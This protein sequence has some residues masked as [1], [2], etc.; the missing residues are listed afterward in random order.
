MVFT[1]QPLDVARNEFRLLRLHPAE[2]FDAP[3][4]VG[5]F[6]A[7]L[8]AAPEYEALSYVWGKPWGDFS[9][10]VTDAR[11]AADDD[12][13]AELSSLPIT[14]Y[15]DTALRQVRFRG[16]DRILWVDALCI[17]Q[18]DLAERSR[19]VQQMRRIYESCVADVAYLGPHPPLP[20]TDKDV[21]DVD[22]DTDEARAAQ[23]VGAVAGETDEQAAARTL[24]AKQAW[25]RS[26]AEQRRVGNSSR[27]AQKLRDGLALMRQIADRDAAALT[28]M[29]QRWKDIGSFSFMDDAE[30][31]AEKD[32]AKPVKDEY[33]P[34]DSRQ[35]RYLDFKQI[36]SLYATFSD[37]EL[38]TRV[39]I[40]QELSCAPRVLLAVGKHH[41]Y[42]GGQ[43]EGDTGG[44]VDVPTD[45]G[46]ED[47]GGGKAD[48]LDTLDTL[49][50]DRD[51]VGGFLDDFA[52]ADAFH[53]SWSHGTVGPAAHRIFSRVRSIHLQRQ[54]IR[55]TRTEH[56]GTGFLRR[57]TRGGFF[58]E[59]EELE[60]ELLKSSVD[61]G[62]VEGKKEAKEAK[63]STVA[64]EAPSDPSLINVL[65]R[66]K[67]TQATDARDKVYG[68]LGLV[69]E[70]PRLPPVDY[71]QPVAS[72]YSD[73]A[74]AIIETSGTLDVISQNPFDGD[75]DDDDNETG[76]K[77]R[78]PG[79]PSW[80]PNFD[81][82]FYTDFYDEFATILFAQRGIYAAGKPDCKHL[83]PLQVEEG[84]FGGVA[85]EGGDAD[86]QAPITFRSLRLRGTMLGRV[87][88]LK[89]G[90]W[91]ENGK[92]YVDFGDGVA[93]FSHYK[94][95]YYDT[96]EGVEG[97]EGVEGGER[98]E[99]GKP[100]S[101]KTVYAATGEP[102]WDAFW[103]TISGD[104][105]AYPIR[106]LTAE[107][108][109]QCSSGLAEVCRLHEAELEKERNETKGFT[110]DEEWEKYRRN[111]VYNNDQ[112]ST[113]LVETLPATRILRR[114]ARRWGMAHTVQDGR[115]P[116][117]GGLLLM[118]RAVAAPGDVVAVLD[119]SK[120]PVVL[121]AQDAGALSTGAGDGDDG[122]TAY[123]KYVCP[124]YVHGYMDGEAVAQV[125]DGRL[126]EQDIVLV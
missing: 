109:A 63:A 120:V 94:K 91:E 62:S 18:Q 95:L 68:L 41:A 4:R 61:E 100:S 56:G 99:E 32:K 19:Q 112:P 72:V 53:S 2:S 5:L 58:Q 55:K 78:A 79:L 106:R 104:C 71:K 74:Q 45:A 38:W 67:W 87:A 39:W 59:E 26:R 51:I 107:E 126:T 88:P 40:V 48:M 28:V 76:A 44:A 89:Q 42:G 121:R 118:V 81:R 60:R 23:E 16:Q 82:S 36:R 93:L 11:E 33:D 52:Y 77:G 69:A 24:A 12:D 54:V 116:S 102:F 27:R 92:S 34:E 108:R 70:A 97:V 3:L 119:G 30:E 73:A 17:N 9:V 122:T 47:D 14:P 7:S 8:D 75:D 124:A 105:T 29:V 115:L 10:L 1:H 80:A 37:A 114:M 98:G 43:D 20:L 90:P 111:K 110:T 35:K 83:L 6:H 21:E 57:S 123:Y 85:G 50:W 86:E 96:I 15:L 22:S 65:A 31:A 49:D 113:A 25:K 84:S 64:N 13:D 46:T 125:A 117:G 103:R 66:F 101:G